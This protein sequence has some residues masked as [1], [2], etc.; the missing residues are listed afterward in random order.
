MQMTTIHLV[1]TVYNT[2]Y[3]KAP[4]QRTKEEKTEHRFEKKYH[5]FIVL[6]NEIGFF[7]TVEL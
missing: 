4:S 5:I 1:G 6:H 2:V 3:S 7:V